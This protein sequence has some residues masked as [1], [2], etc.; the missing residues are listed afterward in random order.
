MIPNLFEKFKAKHRI[1]LPSQSIT[2]ISA[3]SKITPGQGRVEG[4]YDFLSMQ[5]RSEGT[6]SWYKVQG[7]G[8]L[9]P[10]G[11]LPLSHR[12]SPLR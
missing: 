8:Q 11:P 7:L 9:A 2:I 6:T 5:G 1:L 12:R 10:L 4:I 3:K